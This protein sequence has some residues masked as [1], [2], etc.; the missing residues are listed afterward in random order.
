MDAEKTASGEQAIHREPF[1]PGAGYRNVKW[2]LNNCGRYEASLSLLA[3]EALAESERAEITAHLAGCTACRAKL[4]EFQILAR[5]LSQSGQR[6]PEVEAPAS[7][8]RRWMTAVQES[9]REEV[10]RGVLTAPGA[11]V[12]SG[13]APGTARPALEWVSGW[14]SGQRAAWGGLTAIWALVLFFRFSAPDTAKPASLASAPPVSLREVLLALKVEHSS[15]PSRADA[16]QPSQLRQPPD[17]LPPRSQR[18]PGR[19][20]DE[21]VA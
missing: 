14:L 15:L 5:R 12:H 4:V 3:A 8:R 16:R 7:L 13:G 10:G 19:L 11:T 17:A 2:L 21:E 20:A 9:A 6:L 18:W 1:R